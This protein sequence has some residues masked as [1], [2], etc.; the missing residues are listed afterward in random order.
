MESDIY[1]QV[2]RKLSNSS[3]KNYGANQFDVNVPSD[4]LQN[5]AYAFISVV[6]LI[7]VS[8]ASSYFVFKNETRLA[9]VINMYIVEVVS[10]I[11]GALDFPSFVKRFTFKQVAFILFVSVL[12]MVRIFYPPNIIPQITA[13]KVGLFYVTWGIAVFVV[14]VTVYMLSKTAT[15]IFDVLLDI[16]GIFIP[17]FPAT[18]GNSI[19]DLTLKVHSILSN[20]VCNS[21]NWEKDLNYVITASQADLDSVEVRSLP[22]AII[23]GLGMAL[24]HKSEN[25]YKSSIG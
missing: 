19:P 23:L 20:D 3:K 4:V 22:W 24:V 14:S 17:M 25:R 11:L 15:D 1:F 13:I 21:K 12:L 5:K 7:I 16:A 10:T 8:I 18:F 9:L 2:V 6:L